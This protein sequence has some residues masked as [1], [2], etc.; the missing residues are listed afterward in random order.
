MI[1]QEKLSLNC[2]SSSAVQELMRGIRLQLNSLITGNHRTIPTMSSSFKWVNPLFCSWTIYSWKFGS[3]ITVPFVMSYVLR[4]RTPLS[5][6][7]HLCR[8][9][10]G[11]EIFQIMPEWAHFSQGGYSRCQKACTCKIDSKIPRKTCPLPTCTSLFFNPTNTKSFPKNFS[12]QNEA[13]WKKNWARK[14]N[15]EGRRER[16]G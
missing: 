13:L 14:V 9:G 7:L 5:S 11:G 15:E 4:S 8:G 1:Y 10:G 6:Y 2:V 16:N 3:M 12:Y